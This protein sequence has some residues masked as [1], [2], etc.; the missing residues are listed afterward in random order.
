MSRLFKPSTQNELLTDVF[1]IGGSPCSG[2]STIA[3][4]L[5]E[6][7]AFTYYNCDAVYSSHV[8][9]CCPELQPVMTKVKQ[10]SLDE[11]F[12]RPVDQQV[13]ETIQF[14]QEEFAFI[15]EDVKSL[16]SSQPILV[17]GAALLPHLVAPFLGTYNR[18]IWMIPT[19]T[20]QVEQY[21]KRDWIKSILEQCRNPTQSFENWMDR[22]IAFAQC[23][24]QEAV[25]RGFKVMVTDGGTTIEENAALV[26]AH[27]QLK[28]GPE[29]EE[30]DHY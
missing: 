25:D 13:I 24:H 2:K 23:I 1:W 18:G 5:T 11:L 12:S 17:E 4:L 10:L 14:Y 8:S 26:E 16:S 22:D 7:Y 29:H 20:F 30:I 6:K 19:P 15:R 28:G 21:S 27:F 3:E 9:R